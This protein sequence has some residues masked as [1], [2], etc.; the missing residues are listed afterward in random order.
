MARLLGTQRALANNPNNFLINL[1]E[2]LSEE[3][4]M[5]LQLKEELWAMKSRVNWTIF[6]ERSTAY[7]HMATITRRSKNRITSILDDEGVWKHNVEEVKEIFIK[8]FENF[9]QTDQIFCP[10]IQNWDTEWCLRFSD[11][12]A[13]S[14][15]S[16][17]NDHE[18]W[19]ALKSMKPYK[20]P[21]SDGIHAGFFQEVLACGWKLSEK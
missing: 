15:A 9:Y 6:G 10:M 21:G 14:L 19:K 17:P 1:Q 20:A 4:N 8:Y 16:M 18:I 13:N 11:V 2:Q 12:D 3:Y 7:F 5:L